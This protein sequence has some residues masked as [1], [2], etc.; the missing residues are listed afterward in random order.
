MPKVRQMSEVYLR[1]SLANVTMRN[2]TCDQRN[3][4]DTILPEICDHPILAGHKHEFIFRLGR[5]IACD[6][7]SDQ[8]Q[9]MVEYQIAIWR[10]LVHL[11]YHTDYTFK[12]RLCESD[13]YPTQ[14]G[15]P[16]KINRQFEHCPN[17]KHA[18]V[19]GAGTSTLVVGT[20]IAHEQSQ[21]VIEEFQKCDGSCKSCAISTCVFSGT[22]SNHNAEFPEIASP[23]TAIS[24]L[25]KENNADQILTDPSQLKK[26]F[27]SFIWNY[28]RQILLENEITHHDKKLRL[29]VGPA[30]K[31]TADA[32]AALLRD[33][34]AYHVY[35]RRGDPTRT[36]HAPIKGSRYEIMCDPMRISPDDGDFDARYQEFRFKLL[37]VGG[38][39]RC[40]INCIAV[41]DMH[42]QAP[43]LEISS[44]V[45][46]EVQISGNTAMSD[47]D[48]ESQDPIAN[49]EDPN[50]FATDSIPAFEAGD[51]LF[52]VRESLPDDTQVV[53]ELLTGTGEHYERFVMLYPDT[54]RLNNGIP[55]QN[56]I[57]EYL[58]TTTKAVK[59]HASRIKLQLINQG[60]AT[61]DGKRRY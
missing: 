56:R 5:T 59:E 10:A 48:G 60:I 25:R 33:V 14:R 41:Q 40:G 51:A 1:G 49:I 13:S 11:L 6:Y 42:G 8:S 34:G 19:V 58:H 50:V 20:A 21:L 30:D 22:T 23:I 38:D 55:H 54:Q 61:D 32:T 2:L 24:G 36:N 46:D 17:C 4:I 29:I 45:K 18:V 31:V 57:A 15:K 26:Y 39:I 37:S 52:S 28:F 47:H 7:R 9:A 3:R 53:F 12:C 27:G 35:D 16:T 44:P 43:C